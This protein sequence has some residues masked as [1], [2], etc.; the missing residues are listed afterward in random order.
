MNIS[1]NTL[2]HF[3]SQRK[4]LKDI[5]HGKLIP[6]YCVE[7]FEINDYLK[8]DVVIPMK[9]FF[10]IFLCLKYMNILILMGNLQLDL[11]KNGHKK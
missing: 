3:V 2:F 6:R 10:A 7:H 5:L 11:P 8:G 9:C 4:F 1:A